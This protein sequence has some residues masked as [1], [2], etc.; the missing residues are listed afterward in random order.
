MI[1]HEQRWN[2]GEE[3]ILV[4]HVIIQGNL[5]DAINAQ[6]RDPRRKKVK[7]LSF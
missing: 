2:I 7:E 6:K 5:T 1:N 4:A 3:E